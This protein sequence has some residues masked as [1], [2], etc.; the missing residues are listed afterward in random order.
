MANESPEWHSR[1]TLAVATAR[2]A[3][4]ETL[5]WF[6]Q[7]LLAV[8]RKGDGSPVTAADRA[9]ESLMREEISRAF[10]NDAILGEEFGDKP[11]T[12]PYR[13]VLDP[14][15]GTKSFISGVPLYATLVA[16][17]EGN[18]PLIGVIYAPA[19]AEMVYAVSGQTT[20]Y[21]QADA[22]AIPA[23]VSETERLSDA[24]FLASE[25]ASFAKVGRKNGGANAYQQLQDA[26]RLTRTW[27]DAF[28]YLLVA[29]GRADVMVDPI[30]NL[31][32]A[33]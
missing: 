9:A 7:S 33:A 23:R 16:V 8:E 26:C 30:M 4:Q 6:R 3:G 13:W 22:E 27:G 14:I 5:R 19:T 20:W 21:V 24:T 11:G 18:R 29:T 17:M 1:L 12:T 25:A 31:W 15:D 2:A 32:D 10:P 28:G